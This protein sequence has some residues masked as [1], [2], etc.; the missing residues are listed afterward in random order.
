MATH[1]RITS[2][3]NRPISSHQKGGFVKLSQEERAARASMLEAARQRPATPAV[4]LMTYPTR[5]AQARVVAHC[6]IA[7]NPGVK[8]RPRFVKATG[9]VFTPKP[10]K[11]SEQE[12]GWAVK[13]AMRELLLDEAAAFGLRLVFYVRDG[14]RKDID[15]M[16]KLVFDGI[17][18]IAW[19]DDSQVREMMVWSLED[20]AHPRTELLIYK[21]GFQAKV[22]HH[23]E[24]CN[25]RFRVYP[26]WVRRLYCS[27]KCASFAQ[28]NR[29]LMSCAHCGAELER[30]SAL[31]NRYREYFCSI[32]C[33]SDHHSQQLTC[34]HCQTIFHRPN[35]WIHKGQNSFCSAVCRDQYWKDHRVSPGQGRCR[36]CDGATT[37]K[38]YTI[39]VGCRNL[40]QAQPAL[41]IGSQAAKGAGKTTAR[42]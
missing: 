28:R 20:A 42:A 13:Q 15:N 39:C 7:G 29:I 23:C 34:T 8:Q 27:R 18:G 5:L 12:I 37:K 14:Q 30:I 31:A 33:K 35:S 2:T 6:T 38:E 17:T 22:F 11:E 3:P 10:T 16:T 25:K 21:L 26:S 40:P 9:A 24:V 41:P 32:Q 36:V 4:N 1:D 19:E